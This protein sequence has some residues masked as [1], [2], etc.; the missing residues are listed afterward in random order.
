MKEREVI[1]EDGV[2][3][4]LEGHGFRSCFDRGT[5]HPGL[6]HLE[7]FDDTKS[8]AVVRNWPCDEPPPPTHWTGTNIDAVYGRS[9]DGRHGLVPRGI[10]IALSDLSDHLPVISDW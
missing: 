1:A 6:P 5:I 7:P 3:P 4:F 8:T 10:F 9:Q 2:A